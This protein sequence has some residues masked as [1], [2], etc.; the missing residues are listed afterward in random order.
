MPR[1]ALILIAVGVTALGGCGSSTSSGPRPS[2]AVADK[3]ARR[4][5]APGLS[6]V[7]T[8]APTGTPANR[9]AVTVI[10]AWSTALRAGHVRIAARYFSVPSELVNGGGPG[11]TVTLLKINTAAQAAAANETLPC[12]AK[13]VSADQRGRYVNALFR[14]TGRRGPGGDSTC[15]GAAGQTARTNFLIVDGRIVEWIRAPDDPG[16]NGSPGARP[17]SGS[18]SRGPLV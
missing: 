4:L 6:Q 13:F 9:A 15:G 12:G 11:G 2:S 16:D 5:L 1:A 18:G 10:R 17:G 14:L 3:A 7:P 8:P